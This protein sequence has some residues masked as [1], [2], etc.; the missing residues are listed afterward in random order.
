MMSRN[1]PGAWFRASCMDTIPTS[2]LSCSM[3]SAASSRVKSIDAG[4]CGFVHRS[5][6][7]PHASEPLP[8]DV[9]ARDDSPLAPS[10]TN[11]FCHDVPTRTPPSAM[12]GI[13][14]ADTNL[15]PI[16]TTPGDPSAASPFIQP[17][18]G[19]VAWAADG[20]SCANASGNA[21]VAPGY[22]PSITAATTSTCVSGVMTS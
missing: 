1:A 20:K 8:T 3:L 6:G 13:S 12:E 10:T 15:S 19:A 21:A 17:M 7:S 11:P 2:R 5:R 4:S 16:T 22:D 14:G 9:R 18:P